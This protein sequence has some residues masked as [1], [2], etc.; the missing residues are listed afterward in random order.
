MKR[1]HVAIFTNLG[2]G[3]VYPTLGLC[4]ELIKRGYRVTYATN[5]QYAARIH[6]TGAEP[7]IF[8]PAE[9]KACDIA[10]VTEARRGLP[11]LDPRWWPTYASIVFPW[12]LNDATATLPQV[13]RFYSRDTPDLVIYDRFAFAGRILARRLEVPSVQ[14]SFCLAPYQNYL[15][16]Q[17]GVFLTPEPML[18]FAKMLDSFLASHGI[19]E[20][21]NLC[22]IEK[23]NIY[24]LPRAFQHCGDWFDDRFCFVGA[25]LN[26]P[27]E[28]TWRDNSVGKPILLISGQSDGIDNGYFRLFIDALSGLDYHVILSVGRHIS[29]ASL[30]VIP[31]NFEVNRN[32]YHLEML[33][34]TALTICQV[35]LGTTLE[36]IY[37]GVPLIAV[38]PDPFTEETAYRIAELGVGIHLP[39]HTMTVDVIREKVERALGDTSVADR[40]KHMQKV[41]K[42][43]GGA[44]QAAD[45]IEKFLGVRGFT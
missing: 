24:F 1:R 25:C 23:L 44:P 30:G 2:N 42:G 33:P 17:N 22:H 20:A 18:E 38:P 12:F 37:Y 36:S 41:F 40:V 28:P 15:I 26:R 43:S 11:V 21:D 16:R 7:V 13:E 29:D 5:E 45:R 27:F 14:V 31:E 8:S 4:S 32:R 6:Q 19:D 34:R 39:R 10:D 3:H 9:F 35:G